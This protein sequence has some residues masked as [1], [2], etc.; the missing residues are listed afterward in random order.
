MYA[1]LLRLIP[2]VPLVALAACT[3][4]GAPDD[5]KKVEAKAEVAAAATAGQA[6][7]PAP[8]LDYCV[9]VFDKISECASPDEKALL[10]GLKEL[11]MKDCRERKDR[12]PEEEKAELE[13]TK[14]IGCDA[15]KQCQQELSDKLRTP[16][17]KREVAAALKTGEGLEEALGSC[18]Y[19][20]IEDDEFKKQCGELLTKSIETTTREIEAI[21]DRA[22]DGLGRCFD[23]KA[24][25]EKVS[26]EALAK[27]EALCKEVE[28]ARRAKEA[29][30]EATKNA[31]AGTLEVPYQCAMAVEDLEPLPS[32][33][34]KNRLQEV[35][36]ACYVE[37]GKK[38]LPAT[39][40]KVAICEYQVEQVYKAVKKYDLKDAALDPWIAK[41]ARKCGKS[42]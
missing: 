26:P 13:C 36:R 1:R 5:S 27:A 3:G 42:P 6:G 21:R 18:K 23:L 10:E 34:A 22:E 31:E 40:G 8:Q 16:R 38:I 32:D 14:K 24:S 2:V 19:S 25:A 35:V 37:L 15:Y 12:D 17:I 41:A 29:I 20:E 11:A 39:V 28:A 7:T 9:T 4:A 33:W 30:A